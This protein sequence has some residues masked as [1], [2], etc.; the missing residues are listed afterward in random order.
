MFLASAAFMCI[1]TK[2]VLSRYRRDRS[3]VVGDPP[4]QVCITWLCKGAVR[5]SGPARARS[6]NAA[7]S[8]SERARHVP[9]GR[10]EEGPGRREACRASCPGLPVPLRSL[11][12]GK[13]RDASESLKMPRAGP[14]PGSGPSTGKT[15]PYQPPGGLRGT[16]PIPG[17]PPDPRLAGRKRSGILHPSRFFAALEEGSC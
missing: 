8:E 7:L 15:N 10:S 11:G 6:D 4:P 16:R 9:A 14:N 13:D 17:H 1:S 2:T 5:R 12:R 3:P